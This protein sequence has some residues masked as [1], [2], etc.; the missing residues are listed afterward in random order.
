M[1]AINMEMP[2]DCIGCQVGDSVPNCPCKESTL[3][4]DYQNKRHP[5]CPLISIEQ[6]DDCVSRQALMSAFPISDSY[7]LED[8]CKTISFMPPVTPTHETCK[9][10]KHWKDSDGVYRR[11]ISAESKCPLNI[12]QVF[13]GNFYCADFEKRGNENG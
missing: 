7:T 12:L 5:N 4:F 3:L 11:G 8:I 10:C 2:K 9:D 6:S 13:D 1:I